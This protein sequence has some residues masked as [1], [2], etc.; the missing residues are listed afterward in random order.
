MSRAGAALSLLAA[1]L[2]LGGCGGSLADHARARSAELAAQV[3]PGKTTRA[4]V[5]ARF[6]PTPPPISM[7][8]PP[9]GWARILSRV[10][11]KAVA[12][13]RRT[14]RTPAR[15]ERYLTP[16][17]LFSLCY[18]WFYYDADDRVID[19]EWEYASD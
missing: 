11:S 6:G 10:A 8:R 12:S 14:G 5:Q 13:E 9:D 18:C 4:D 3:P 7:T 19:V 17:G 15:V 16:D 1:L 2:L